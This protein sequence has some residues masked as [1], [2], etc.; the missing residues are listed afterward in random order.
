MGPQSPLWSGRRLFSK[1]RVLKVLWQGD[2]SRCHKRRSLQSCFRVWPQALPGSPPL[3]KAT[4]FYVILSFNSCQNQSAEDSEP[5]IS[6]LWCSFRCWQ[7]SQGVG[8]GLGKQGGD[9]LLEISG[10]C[11]QGSS[12]EGTSGS[13]DNL[14]IS[15]SDVDKCKD[16]R[17]RK[18]K[19]IRGKITQGL[20]KASAI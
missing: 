2:D 6:W 8:V 20:K 9:C 14:L 12:Q 18:E 13:S 5:E 19:N 10:S 4:R 3:E 15:T 7:H 16:W 11:L 17:R 1:N